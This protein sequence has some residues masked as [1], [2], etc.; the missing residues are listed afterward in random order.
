MPTIYVVIEKQENI[1]F[2]YELLSG[3]LI[4]LTPFPLVLVVGKNLSYILIAFAKCLDPD[5]AR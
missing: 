1:V 3:G 2:N 4:L 5:H